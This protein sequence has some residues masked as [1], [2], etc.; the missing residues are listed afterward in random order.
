MGAGRFGACG[1]SA[2]APS[3]LALLASLLALPVSSRGPAFPTFTLGSEAIYRCGFDRDVDS[4]VNG[5]QRAEE[6]S[7][8]P[9]GKGS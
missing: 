8:P 3:C 9:A 2:W 6:S 5:E 4:W 1:V 7:S